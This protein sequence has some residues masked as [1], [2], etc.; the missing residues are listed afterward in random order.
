MLCAVGW[1]LAVFLVL[2]L[3]RG[4]PAADTLIIS[5]KNEA[6]IRANTVL[7]GDVANLRNADPNQ[8]QTLAQV[9]L[10]PA[11]ELGS[12]LV[13]TRRQISEAINSA[14][15]PRSAGLFTGA[16][17]VQVRRQG[18]PPDAAEIAA[19]LQARILKTTSWNASEIAIRSMAGLKGIELPTDNFELRI[20]SDPT[21]AGRNKILAAIE[22]V[23]GGKVQRCFWITAEVSVRAAVLTA[24]RKI[25]FEKIIA[26]DDV[27]ETTME[28]PD[29]RAAYVRR[30]EDLVGKAARRSFSPGDLLTREAFTDPVL[31]RHGETVQLRLQRNGILLTSLVRA[32][33]DGKL[34]QVITVRNLDFSAVLKAQV[35]GR[36]AVRV[37]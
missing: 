37:Q 26:S 6:S 4:L 11:P 29:I 34:G 32:E 25:P 5:L 3:T 18:M 14:L 33:Q 9:A 27:A 28:I 8:L 23:S 30:P 10:A 21:F 20:A 17:V 36:A 13:L 1:V 16:A 22:V 2:A 31:V 19:V 7:L 12:A 35:T 24:A 15:G